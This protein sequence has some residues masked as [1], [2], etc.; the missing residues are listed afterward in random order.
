VDFS[1]K[2]STSSKKR[3]KNETMSGLFPEY[4]FL[5]THYLIFCSSPPSN[6][7]PT[8]YPSSLNCSSSSSR[9][10]ECGQ[11]RFRCP[12]PVGNC[13][14]MA[15]RLPTGRHYPPAFPRSPLPPTPAYYHCRPGI[16][17]A[18][19]LTALIF[20]TFKTRSFG[21]PNKLAG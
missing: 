11:R 14:A 18:A 7:D 8:F 10:G 3:T 17:F 2:K 13:V 15:Y 16:Y 20:S 9:C 12:S 1:E 21:M 5:L 6:V 19:H 4:N